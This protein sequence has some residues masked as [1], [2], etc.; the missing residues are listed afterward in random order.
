MSVDE[1][2]Q[3]SGEI[4]AFLIDNIPK[5]GGHLASNL[6]TVELTVALH[7]VFTTP[8]DKFVF[9]VGHQSYAH[10]L[11]TGRYR[12]FSALRSENG[13]SGFPR[14]TESKHDAFIGGHSSISIS[15]AL[16]I[17]K[18]MELRGEKGDVV[19]VIG[20]GALTGGEAYEG[21]NNVSKL[22]SNLIIVLNDNQMSISKN[23]GVIA[24][25]LTKMRSSKSYYDKKEAVKQFLDK[26]AVGKE[27]SK[28][29][30]GTK[31]LIKFAIY[32]SNIFE[33]LGFKYLGPVD[34]HNLEKLI[35]V[36]TVARL[37]DEPCIVHVKTKKGKGYAPAEENSGEYHG[38]TRRNPKTAH[39]LSYS[40]I[41]GR[42]L[43]CIAKNDNR[44]CAV[45][46]AMKYATGLQHF[47]KAF[48]KRFFDVGIAEQ[49]ALTFSCGLAAQGMIPVF[50][51]YSTFLQ[52][53]FDQI[54][55]D[56]AIEKKHIII[57][58]D[59]A[60]FVGEDGET[61]QGL[62]DIPLLLS[63][64]NVKIYTPIDASALR[65]SLHK[66]IGEDDGI[67]VIRYP[68]AFS[69]ELNRTG[70]SEFEYTGKTSSILLVSYGRLCENIVNHSGA[71]SLCLNIVKPIPEKA[72]H[73]ILEYEQV[74]FFEEGMKSG[75]MGERLLSELYAGGFKG[76][77][78]ITAVGEEFVPA[79][80]AET[81][82]R[83]FKLDRKSIEKMVEDERQT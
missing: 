55:H 64:P 23:H 65:F 36:F 77:F 69:R 56:A 81:Q 48:P 61:H 41:M 5:T 57:C 45:T 11:I 15:A 37:A 33:S 43:C 70:F 13:I 20:D 8:Q 31:D 9:D 62:F 10:K 21:L 7:K 27:L 14:S 1:L 82:L 3:L 63:V 29:I 26:S 40:E 2:E 66:A 73:I 46:A 51:V 22:S 16:G 67:C 52:R 76:S 34:G 71:D 17:A 60:G 75:G 24:D 72:V 44:V 83:K 74:L 32:Q 79:A 53:C 54:I 19:A 28:S 78:R 25:Y 35:E 18:A 38:V 49:H 6:G 30:S 12:D 59:R 4:R 68:R 80:E 42:E 58:V 39:T 50:A 47:A